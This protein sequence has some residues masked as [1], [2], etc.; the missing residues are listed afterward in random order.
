MDSGGQTV[1]ENMKEYLLNT[2]QCTFEVG[3]EKAERLYEELLECTR[4][5][6]MVLRKL[7]FILC[8][9]SYFKF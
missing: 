1:L 8:Y 4:H 7:N 6:N 9:K 5:K 2:I 3:Q